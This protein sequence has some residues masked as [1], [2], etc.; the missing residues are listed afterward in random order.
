MIKITNVNINIWWKLYLSTV[1]CVWIII[2][3]IIII[4]YKIDFVKNWIFVKITVFPLP[5]L[6]WF[7][8]IIKKRVLGIIYFWLPKVPIIDSLK[9]IEV[10][11]WNIDQNQ[12]YNF[13][14]LSY[15]YV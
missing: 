14:S 3:V 13:L 6:F 1:I 15:T 4:Y 7:F 5:I 9:V 2:T 10:K 12:K 8:I 11:D